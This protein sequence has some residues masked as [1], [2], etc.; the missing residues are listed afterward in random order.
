MSNKKLTELT[1]KKVKYTNAYC[2]PNNKNNLDLNDSHQKSAN[3]YLKVVG[4]NKVHLSIKTVKIPQEK[5]IEKFSDF[6]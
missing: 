5:V 2:W 4:I 6:G 3:R 1:E